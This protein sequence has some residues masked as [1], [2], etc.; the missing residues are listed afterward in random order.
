M[1]TY[2]IDITSKAI[3]SFG[4]S[5]DLGK[6]LVHM[7]YKFDHSEDS[8]KVKAITHYLHDTTGN[9]LVV[10]KVGA[11][12]MDYRFIRVVID[13]AAGSKTEEEKQDLLRRTL[14]CCM[15]YERKNAQKCEIEVRVNEVEKGDV[16]R[17]YPAER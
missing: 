2:N 7:H 1:A 12:M 4:S 6:N 3:R 11:D 10:G 8:N 5:S 14:E 9:W 17:I 15:D 16:V 13:I